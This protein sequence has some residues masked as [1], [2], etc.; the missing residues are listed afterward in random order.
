LHV[1]SKMQFT[2]LTY[3]YNSFLLMKRKNTNCFFTEKVQFMSE[4]YRW[5]VNCELDIFSYTKCKTIVQYVHPIC[6][7]DIET[8]V[9]RLRH[10]KAVNECHGK[11][12]P[13]LLVLN[14]FLMLLNDWFLAMFWSCC[15]HLPS[16]IKVVYLSTTWK[17][18]IAVI[19]IATIY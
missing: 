16:A 10:I 6:R 17:M 18:S 8:N 19:F 4:T 3:T 9:W 7:H 5:C 15:M 12:W 13:N 14:V 2:M 11:T 1:A